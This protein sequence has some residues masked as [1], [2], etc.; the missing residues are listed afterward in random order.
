MGAQRKNIKLEEIESALRTTSGNVSAAA[1]GLSIGRATLYRR[2]AESKTLQQ[3]LVDA[4]EELVDLA[5]TMLRRNVMDGN[6]QAIMF[7]LRTLGKNRGYVERVQATTETLAVD[8]TALTDEQLERIANGES[9]A[10]V[11][12][13]PGKGAGDT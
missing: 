11:L 4:R 10:S 9:V 6:M 8:M 12:A 1:R 2:I 3:V 5:E 7:A 13:R